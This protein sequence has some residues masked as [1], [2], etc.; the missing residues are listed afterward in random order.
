ML[1]SFQTASY[2]LIISPLSEIVVAYGAIWDY[3]TFTNENAIV[4]TS[5]G[6]NGH[7]S[8]LNASNLA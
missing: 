6:G 8:R 5:C 2:G 3:I 4:I 1:R 7:L